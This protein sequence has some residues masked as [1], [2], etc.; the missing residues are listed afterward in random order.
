[1]LV[2]IVPIRHLHLIATSIV[3]CSIDRINPLRERIEF[4]VPGRS[5]V[6]DASLGDGTPI[7]ISWFV[8]GL[9]CPA[10]PTDED[11]VARQTVRKATIAARQSIDRFI[12]PILGFSAGSSGRPITGGLRTRAR[13]MGS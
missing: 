10:P 12:S 3:N 7:A 6:A 13:H 4:N 2:G 11:I 9:P 8:L 1:M 5:L